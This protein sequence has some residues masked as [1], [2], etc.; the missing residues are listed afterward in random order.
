[1][2]TPGT[3][4]TVYR[5]FCLLVHYVPFF[6][7]TYDILDMLS[8]PHTGNRREVFLMTIL[9]HIF[10]RYLIPFISSVLAGII[11][12]YIYNKLTEHKRDNKE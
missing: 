12:T 2:Q 10:I 9:F 1:M 4:I 5:G 7:L 6:V 11:S 8:H 3:L